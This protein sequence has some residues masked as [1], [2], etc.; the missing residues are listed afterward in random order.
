MEMDLNAYPPA[1]HEAPLAATAPSGALLWQ[2]FSSGVTPALGRGAVTVPVE[3]AASSN[4]VPA[5]D[6]SALRRL[7]LFRLFA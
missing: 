1:S 3:R 4:A 5:S 6:G 7:V 2:R